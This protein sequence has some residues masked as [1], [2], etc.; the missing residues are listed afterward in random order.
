MPR[1]TFKEAERERGETVDQLSGTRGS[2][3]L[4]RAKD[5]RA[6]LRLETSCQNKACIVTLIKKDKRAR[7]REREGKEE[8]REGR[9]GRLLEFGNLSSSKPILGKRCKRAFKILP[10]YG[11]IPT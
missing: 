5:V 4:V 3:E 6:C 2:K 8:A 11:L 9:G 10:P 1:D 7:E